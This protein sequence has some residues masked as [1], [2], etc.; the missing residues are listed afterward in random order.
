MPLK[1]FV[2]A[3]EHRQKP[4]PGKFAISCLGC[5]VN[6]AEVSWLRAELEKQGFSQAEDHEAA[7]IALVMTCAVTAAAARQSRQAARR[8]LDRHPSARTVA[9]GCGVQ[10]EPGAYHGLGCTVLGR[11]RLTGL[12]AMAAGRAPW[13]QSERIEPPDA[14]PFCPGLSRVRP[15]RSRAQLKVQDGC[16]AHCAYCI[17]PSTRG[18]PR[19]L[20]LEAAVESFKKLAGTGAPEVVLT[21]IHL[22][23]YGKDLAGP[24]GLLELI[25]ALLASHPGPR[26]RLSSLEVNEVSNGLLSL[27]ASEPRICPHLHIP[28]QSGSDKVLSAMGRP[29]TREQF[30]ERV[31]AAAAMLPNAALGADVLVGLPG[32]D[33]SAYQDT[34]DLIKMLPLNFLHVFPYSPRPGT[35]AASMKNRPRGQTVKERASSLRSLGMRKRMAFHEDQAGN[36]LEAIV[37]AGGLARSG[38]YCLIE[39]DGDLPPGSRVLVRISGCIQRGG[40]VHLTGHLL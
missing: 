29:Y 4:G 30:I 1:R 10:A 21:G 18:R 25:K 36:R 3:S 27:M 38:N 34:Y 22:G 16:D 26:L 19:S 17:V 31:R 11:S 15:G 7:D 28:L 40:Q 35:P 33:A 20:P 13:P 39:L 9:T 5:K 8:L 32:E 12:V 2:S 14:G 37:E 23:M 24:E 6:Q